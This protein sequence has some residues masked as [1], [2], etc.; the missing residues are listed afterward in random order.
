MSIN[1]YIYSGIR[2]GVDNIPLCQ[3]NVLFV[4]SHNYA[5]QR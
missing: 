2:V 3:E 5:S 1:S 4:R